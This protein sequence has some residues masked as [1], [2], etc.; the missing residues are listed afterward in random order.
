M[1]W[2]LPRAHACW[3]GASMGLGRG[4]T[5]ID[6]GGV[7]RYSDTLS[8]SGSELSKAR[9]HH[10]SEAFGVGTMNLGVMQQFITLVGCL[11]RP[12]V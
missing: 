6:P 11:F 4:G 2:S 12:G 9:P 3:P 7:A 10:I 5:P 8:A 1:G